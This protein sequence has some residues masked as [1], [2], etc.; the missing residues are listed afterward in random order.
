M[1]VTSSKDNVDEEQPI[2]SAKLSEDAEKTIEVKTKKLFQYIYRE[3]EKSALKYVFISIIVRTYDSFFQ[4]GYKRQIFLFTPGEE[5]EEKEFRNVTI[6][7]K[8]DLVEIAWMDETRSRV[9]DKIRDCGIHVKEEYI[10]KRKERVPGLP[11]RVNQFHWYGPT[12]KIICTWEKSK[13]AGVKKRVTNRV[14]QA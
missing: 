1:G 2:L 11:T 7:N 5:K 10:S 14:M 13:P 6:V 9:L 3:T 8:D 4:R 12:R